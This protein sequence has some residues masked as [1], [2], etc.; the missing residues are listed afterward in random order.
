MTLNRVEV[1][2]GERSYPVL[3]GAQARHELDHVLPDRARRVAIVTQENIPWDVTT[4]R[5][6]G[7]FM[8]GPDE[9]YKT[10]STIEGLCSAFAEFGLTRRD[11]VVGVG[12]GMVTDIAGFAAATYH[13]GLPVVHVATTLLGQVDAAIG[14][15]TGVNLE[16]GKN[17]VGAYWQPEAVLCDTETLT[18]LTPR[19]WRCG[20]GEV[21]KYQWIGQIEL[22]DLD[23]DAQI[24]ACVRIKAD[25]VAA[26]EREAGRRALLNYGHTL[27]HAVEIATGHEVAHGEAVAVGL[28]FAAEL[29]HALGRIDE[30]E[31][32]HHY[33]V[34]D[35]FGLAARPPA[36]LDPDALVTLMGADKKALGSLTFV[37]LDGDHMLQVVDDVSADTVRAVLSDFLA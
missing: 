13:R 31:V 24:A 14:G 15:K 28:A 6:A 32:A 8:V 9:T 26:D 23:L 34:L 29:A 25:I 3:I 37:M 21:A 5:S 19:E 7:V 18:T 4:E 30:A 22:R 17:L 1:D 12:G 27:A 2:L 11:C 10:L 35:A 33:E 16:Q 20:R 36:G